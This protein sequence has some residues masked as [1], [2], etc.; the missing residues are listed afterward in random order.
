MSMVFYTSTTTPLYSLAWQPT[1]TASYA[2]TCIFLII[3]T[4]IFRLLLAGKT[5]LERRWLDKALERRYISVAGALSE[6]DKIE[7][8]SDH[9]YGTLLS[10]NGLEQRVKVVTNGARPILPWRLS[11]DLPR[12]AY[13]TV[14]AGVGYLIMLAIMTENVG[15]FMSVLGGVFL[16][17][18]VVGRL[19]EFLVVNMLPY[20]SCL[21]AHVAFGEKVAHTNDDQRRRRTSVSQ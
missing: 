1:S 19:L 21:E 2:G 13:V 7:G 9:E 4:V 6:A 14:T 17:E 5:I 12:A 18:L 16:G 3:F 11:V 10:P 15:Y 8:S 20:L